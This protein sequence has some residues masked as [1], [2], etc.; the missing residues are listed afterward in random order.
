MNR[1]MFDSSVIDNKVFHNEVHMFRGFVNVSFGDIARGP[2]GNVTASA[3]AHIGLKQGPDFVK[4][5]MM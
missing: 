2:P 4:S 1:Q 3:I 5:R